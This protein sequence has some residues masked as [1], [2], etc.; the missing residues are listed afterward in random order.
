MATFNDLAVELQETI[1]ELVLPERGIHWIQI[2]GIPHEPKYIRESIRMTEW[3]NFDSLPD[4]C[5]D[6]YQ[7]RQRHPDFNSRAQIKDH[8][9]GP[10][11][12]YLLTTVPAVLG[13]SQQGD[14]SS[15]GQVDGN[16]QQSEAHNGADEV[17]YTHR[18]RQLSTYTQLTVLLST[19]RL[20]RLVSMRRIEADRDCSWLLHRSMGPLYRPRPMD[21][22]RAQYS[23]DDDDDSEK[24]P[25]G[26]PSRSYR[27][28]DK[29]TPRIHTLDLAVF[30]LHDSQGRATPLLRYAPWQYS[31]ETGMHSTTFAA[32]MRVG[33]E[34]HASW[35]MPAGRDELRPHAI[36]AIV[37]MMTLRRF[38]AHIYWLVDGVP[39]PNWKQDYPAAISEIFTSRIAS[40]KDSALEELKV[41][42][43]LSEEKRMA[44]LADY[45]LGQ[46]FEANGRR[47]YIV[48]L[49]IRNYSLAE[50]ALLNEVG[51]GTNGPFLGGADLWPE[52][53][54]DPIQLAHKVMDNDSG[55]LGTF[56]P[57]SFMLSW[58]PM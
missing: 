54:R 20:S 56:K 49:V 55:N 28:W 58:E 27:D 34:W 57:V 40:M 32:F 16:E 48:G 30:R 50:T 21:V 37:R 12:R 26:S 23:N 3:H 44:L 29:L 19:C 25:Y 47:Y 17:A 51:L 46:E 42:W 13:K 39:R 33:I 4:K 2:E 43:E 22:W 7:I 9:S 53:L 8:E 10:F 11:F 31:I 5:N 41:T 18:C 1:W 45:H 38:P 24:V 14:D 15:I 36:Q 52:A 6:V 35:A